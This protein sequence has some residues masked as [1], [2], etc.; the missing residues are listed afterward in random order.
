[1][2]IC[3]LGS[4]SRGN[5]TL[6]HLADQLLLVDCGFGLKETIARV[7]SVG[8]EVEKISALLVTHEHGDHVSGVESLAAKFDIPVYM[9]NGT[10][11][12]WKSRGRVTA[13]PIRAGEEFTIGDVKIEPVAVPHDAREPVQFVFRFESIKL[14]VLTDLGSLTPHVVAAYSDCT[15]LFVEANHDK[16]M[17][18]KGPYPAPLKNRVGGAWGHLNNLQTAELIRQIN[19]SNKLRQLIVGHISEQNNSTERVAEA[20]EPVVQDLHQLVYATQDTPLSWVDI[21]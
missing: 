18:E 17:L 7:K 6:I 2:Q 14:G 11:N 10:S 3:S 9:T 15:A 12:S 21:S 8:C 1:M 19:S 16:R 20:L 13:K 5:A 4:G